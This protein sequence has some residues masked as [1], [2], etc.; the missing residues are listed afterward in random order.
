MS[1]VSP[2]MPTSRRQFLTGSARLAAGAGLA[3]IIAIKPAGATPH[4]LQG[5]IA[6]VVGEATVR[7]GKVTLSVPPLVENGN[8]VPLTVSVDSPMTE[9]EH[10]KAIHIFNEKNPQPYVLTVRLGPRAG[11][12]L[13]ATRI[14]LADSQLLTAVAE[15]SDGT[16]WSATADI[17]VTIAACI[18]DVK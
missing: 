8:T 4:A 7:S 18:E 2:G 12:A 14:K 15:L 3:S 10:V 16:F 11:K 1:D 17:I 13:I 6:E 5:A 9:A